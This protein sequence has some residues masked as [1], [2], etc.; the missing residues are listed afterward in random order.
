MAIE[1]SVDLHTA[2]EHRLHTID[3]VGLLERDGRGD[4]LSRHLLKELHS[5]LNRGIGEQG[6]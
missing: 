1:D 2:L 3:D 6:L 4:L 5:P